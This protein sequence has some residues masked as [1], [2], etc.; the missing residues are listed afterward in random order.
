MKTIYT[1]GLEVPEPPHFLGSDPGRW[2]IILSGN[3]GPLEKSTSYVMQVLD[4]NLNT[5]FHS[6][7]ESSKALEAEVLLFLEEEL[8]G[9]R[10]DFL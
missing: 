4:E 8:E 10:W 6:S 5:L 7:S 1:R 9:C 2:E 3:G